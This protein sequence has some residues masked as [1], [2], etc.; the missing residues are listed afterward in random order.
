MMTQRNIDMMSIVVDKLAHG[1]TL[2][3][4]LKVVYTKR[5]VVIPQNNKLNNMKVMDLEIPSRI[6][7][8]LMRNHLTTVGE[9]IKFADESSIK[10][11]KG[12]GQNNSIALFEAI[13]DLH[14]SN[15]SKEEQTDFL[16]DTVKRNEYYIKPEL[17]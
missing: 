5:N 15:M 14:W 8:A 2:S 4:A 16:I 3:S 1:K 12:F 11:L 13:L 10:Q 6:K 9:V 17:K 7:N